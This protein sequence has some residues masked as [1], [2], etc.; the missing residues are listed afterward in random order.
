MLIK[1]TSIV[2]QAF[3]NLNELLAMTA[4]LVLNQDRKKI[5]PQTGFE[6]ATPKLS[7]D[8]DSAKE[9][10]LGQSSFYLIVMLT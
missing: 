9:A 7:K 10:E 3:F 1:F 5:L 4:H 8:L 2:I 6:P